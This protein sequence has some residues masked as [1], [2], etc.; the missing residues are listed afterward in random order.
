MPARS[1]QAPCNSRHDTSRR[2]RELGAQLGLVEVA[3]CGELEVQPAAVKCRP[4]TVRPGRQVGDEHVAVEVGIG[5]RLVRWRNV[6]A[7][8]PPA[9]TDDAGSPAPQAAPHAG[10]PA[11]EISESRRGG[12]LVAGTHLRPHVFGPERVQQTDRLRRR[13]GAVVG[14]D[15]DPVVVRREHLARRR[16]DTR[17]HRAKGGTV[18]GSRQTERSGRPSRASARRA[19]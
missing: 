10:A 13:V 8:K 11:L 9:G 16:V 7:T 6:A 4:A 15:A 2:R 17:E 18:D 14:G 12:L 1:A 5:A 3:G 19:R